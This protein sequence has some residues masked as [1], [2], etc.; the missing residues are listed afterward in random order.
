MDFITVNF[1]KSIDRSAF[2]CEV[3]PALNAYIAQHA[4]QDEKRNVSRTFMY[5]ERGILLGYYA[6]ANASV[7]VDELSEDQKKRMPRYPMPAVLLSRLA[8]DKSRQGVGLGQRLMSDFF[9]RV[10]TVSKQSGVAFV[11][12]DAKDQ[13]AA[14]YYQAKLGF[15]ASTNNPRRLILSTATL[16][17]GFRAVA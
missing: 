13:R 15:V 17:K 8:I 2:D 9:R 3:H 10:Y 14:S 4:G 6:L 12:V 16:I 5:I 7:A 1:N 11:V